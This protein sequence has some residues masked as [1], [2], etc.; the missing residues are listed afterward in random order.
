[1]PY[2]RSIE[3]DDI[4]L[5][6]PM[7]FGGEIIMVET[8]EGAKKAFGL[9]ASEKVVGFDTETRPSF[10]KGESYLPAILQL[11]TRDRAY[12]FR[13]DFYTPPQ[14]LIDFLSNPKILKVGVGIQD[15]LRGLGKLINFTPDGY[16]DLARV[17]KE[18]NIENF[19]LRALTAIFLDKRLLK[20][21]KV[22]NWEMKQL[23]QAQIL[24]A[25][26][27]AVVGLLIYEEMKSFEMV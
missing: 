2:K 11:A 5:L 8:L 21:A 20:G 7:E 22:T 26:T 23:S 4:A 15:D 3:K 1:M 24:Y 16:V 9:L 6:P 10:S 12:L 13:L 19:G 25:A 17:A 27:D 18:H 14:E